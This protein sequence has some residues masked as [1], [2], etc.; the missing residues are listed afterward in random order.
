MTL[1]L[2]LALVTGCVESEYCDIASRLY[3]DTEQTV[4]WLL[5]NDRDLLT[6]IVVHNEQTTRLCGR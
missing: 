6:G 1:I 5:E 3:F 2:P 4:D